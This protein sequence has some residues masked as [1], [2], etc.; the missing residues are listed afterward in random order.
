[1]L[2]DRSLVCWGRILGPEIVNIDVSASAVSAGLGNLISVDVGDERACGVTSTRGDVVC[3]GRGMARP[4]N[5]N[6]PP[7][8]DFGGTATAVE[9]PSDP[10]SI[11]G[12]RNARASVV[13]V[14]TDGLAIATNAFY[15]SLATRN[16]TATPTLGVST[17]TSMHIEGPRSCG[18]SQGAV[19]CIDPNDTPSRIFLRS[20]F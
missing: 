11:G 20:G 4:P 8:T 5:H 16:P 14:D 10:F 9:A 19:Y 12:L 13:A 3:V 6:A 7:I 1:M 17:M 2:Q 15:I 18:V